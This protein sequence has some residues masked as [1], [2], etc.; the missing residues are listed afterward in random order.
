MTNHAQSGAQVILDCL[1]RE[2]VDTIFGYPG[3]SAIPLFDALLDSNIK[4][5]L[6][7][8]EQGATHMADGYARA[9]G[10]VGVVLVTSGPGATNTF[11]GIYTALMDSSPIV[12]LAAQT[13]TPN[14]GKDAFQECDTS[15]MTFA[16][17]KH[18]FLVKNPN[19]LPRIVKEAFHIAR[20][21]RPGPVLI[22]L[23][24]DVTAGNCSASFSDEIHLPG[25]KI[26]THADT[27]S[28]EKAAALLKKSKKPV[29]LVG[30]GALISNASRQVK[31]LAEKLNAPV[32]ET[33]LGLGAFPETHPLSLG[34]VGMHGTA[35]ANKALLECDL[36]MSIGSRF[37]DRITGKLEEFC[38]GA[39]IIHLDIDPAEEGKILQPDAFLCGDAK[40][41]LEQLLPLVSRLDTDE[42]VK[43]IQ[44]YKKRY[45]LTYPK[46]GGLRM[47]HIVSTVYELTKGKAIITTDVGQHQM[48]VA[49]FFKADYPRQFITSGGAGT[50]GFG[51][52]AAIGAAI[53]I[54][55]ESNWPI[56]CFAGDGGFQMT[57]FEM[58][59]AAIHKLPIKIFVMDNK[60]LGMVRQWQDMFYSKRYSSV[61]ME[62][63]PD[64]VK[65]A[66]AYGI[67]GL[68]IKR[69]ADAERIIQKAF[70][71]NEGPV[72][73][74]CECEEE[75]NV[76][77]M[78]PAGAPLTAMLTEQPKGQL[79]KP[80]GST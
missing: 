46:Q 77:P 3:G 54:G 62:G 21:G 1:K 56:C 58:A 75:D 30:H 10:K 78:I 40:L 20:T 63:N 60:Y 38:K 80:T 28:V 18:S 11:T 79:E 27:A 33:L 12:V 73:I 39:T 70:E 24:K 19:D 52:P 44:T 72:L 7:R 2:G 66:E 42:W 48:W 31:E 16:A 55:S 26:P 69:S 17:V 47:Q 57:E 29:L 36:I 6:S 23:P 67:K 74:H 15:G 37:D 8:H 68:R 53:G 51:F 41:V 45:A 43:T 5:V 4:M 49:Q 9:T 61:S 76:F 50:M 59:T 13:T 14:L 71:Y 64:F 34:M 22:D 65:L 25:Y 32:V 35:Y